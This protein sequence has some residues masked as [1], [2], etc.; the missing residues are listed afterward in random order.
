[1]IYLCCANTS[2]K[3]LRKMWTWYSLKI[4]AGRKRID[5][6]PHPPRRTPVN[7]KHCYWIYTIQWH[8][9]AFQTPIRGKHILTLQRN[10]FGTLERRK[11]RA[12]VDQMFM[13]LKRDHELAESLSAVR[14]RKQRHSLSKYRLSDHKLA[15][16]KGRQ[17]KQTEFVVTAGI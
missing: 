17:K 5:R 1:M 10:L 16:Q 2:F 8:A 4:R 7:D 6:S 14:D 13:A 9:C 11:S 12:T 15:N 3:M